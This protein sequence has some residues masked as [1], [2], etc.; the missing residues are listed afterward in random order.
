MYVQD[1]PIID[2][3]QSDWDKTK[4]DRK[5]GRYV[6]KTRNV[7]DYRG[8]KSARPPFEFSWVPLQPWT[9]PPNRELERWRMSWGYT[10][11]TVEDP[12]WPLGIIPDAEGKYVLGDCVLVKTTLEN[13]L[14]KRKREIDESE[15]STKA[16][17]AAYEAEAASLGLAAKA[18]AKDAEL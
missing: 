15:N 12:Y 8:A 14:K 4:S 7:I 16:R 2:L 9:Y 1:H 13:Y 18:L 10:L 11:V 17:Q 3:T 5:A 6:F